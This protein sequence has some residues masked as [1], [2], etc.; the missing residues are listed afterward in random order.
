[1]SNCENKV[2]CTLGYYDPHQ[3]QNEQSAHLLWFCKCIIISWRSLSFLKRYKST[4]QGTFTALI[5]T[6]SPLEFTRAL[7]IPGYRHALGDK[8]HS[9]PFP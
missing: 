4:L 7:C 2:P 8:I 9:L 1:V 3:H 6:I 5:Q